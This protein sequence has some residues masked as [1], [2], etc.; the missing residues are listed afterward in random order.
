M[1]ISIIPHRDVGKVTPDLIQI[2]LELTGS[3]INERVKR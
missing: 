2:T 3:D 1:V